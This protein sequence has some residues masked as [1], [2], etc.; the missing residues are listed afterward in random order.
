MCTYGVRLPVSGWWKDGFRR[1]NVQIRKKMV[2]ES[3]SF[4]EESMTL[5]ICAY[6]WLIRFSSCR[7]FTTFNA[8]PP[9][10]KLTMF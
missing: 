7:N 8:K 5:V 2:A 3:E 9:V 10:H 6:R 4:L 1:T